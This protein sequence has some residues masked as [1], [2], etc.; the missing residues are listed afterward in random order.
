MARRD[1]PIKFV[2]TADWHLG[3]SNLRI[4]DDAGLPLQYSWVEKAVDRLSEYV[5]QNGVHLVFLCGDMLHT[6]SPSPTVE[7]ILARMVRKL[8][9]TGAKVL[10]IPGNHEISAVGANPLTIYQTLDVDGITVFDAPELKTLT[11]F[12]GRS[13]QIAAVPFSHRFSMREKLLELATQVNPSLPAFAM[14][15]ILVEGAKHASGTIKA[16]PDEQQLTP[17]DFNDLPFA[18]VAL[19]HVHKA[20]NVWLHPIA[21]YCGGIQIVDFSEQNEDKGFIVGELHFD[22][23]GY[24]VHREFIPVQTAKYIT[25]RVDVR[26]ESN[27]TEKVLATL[28]AQNIKDAV[29]RVV[30]DRNMGDARISQVEIRAYCER[31]HVLWHNVTQISQTP[32]NA[33]QTKPEPLHKDLL[34][35]I[36]TYIEAEQR[37]FLPMR[38]DILEQVRLLIEEEK[39]ID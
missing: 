5:A 28:A 32:E 39:L 35:N 21:E 30:V 1:E 29:L 15:H 7:N 3:V 31:Q 11:L 24:S 6:K 19:G 4:L 2:H 9:A 13:V 16:L 26:G 36:S 38:D 27:P 25:V 23:N 17:F 34:A 14:M 37:Q 18:Y 20:Q 12:D 8:T 33:A 22:D 10:A